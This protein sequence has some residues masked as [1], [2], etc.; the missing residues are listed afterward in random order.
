[1]TEKKLEVETIGDLRRMLLDE[2]GELRKKQ[3]TAAHLNALVNATGKILSTVK[4]EMEYAK[5]VGYKAKIDF[6]KELKR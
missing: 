6:I 3:T 4:A 1:M 2:I 5:M